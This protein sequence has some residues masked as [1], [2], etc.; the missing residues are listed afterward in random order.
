[1]YLTAL[2]RGNLTLGATEE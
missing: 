1:L 2:K